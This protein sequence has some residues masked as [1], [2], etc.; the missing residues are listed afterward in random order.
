MVVTVT[1]QWGGAH[2]EGLL[3]SWPVAATV[4][5]RGSPLSD[6]NRGLIR[7]AMHRL[8]ELAGEGA[9]RPA[10]KTMHSKRPNSPPFGL[11]ACDFDGTLLGSDHQVSERDRRALECLR[12]KGVLVVVATGRSLFSF[13]RAVVQE[14]P[15]DW[16]VFS[17]GAGIAQW[18]V[19]EVV[20]AVH[21]TC[22]ETASIGAHLELLNAPYCVHDT[23]P[24]N[25]R[26]SYQLGRDSADLRRRI[27]LYAPFS[28]PL[29]ADRLEKEATQVIVHLEEHEAEAG[30]LAL[31]E[32]FEDLGVIRTTSPL[33]HCSTW[34]EIFPRGVSKSS[35]LRWLC[36]H[37]NV[38]PARTGA[39]GND[40][41]DLDMLEWVAHPFVVSN[42]AAPLRARFQVVRSHDSGGVAE[43]VE[44][45]LESL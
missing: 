32:H 6:E 1:Q 13:R 20:H 10:R 27:E 24:N 23:I 35:G 9:P 42:A 30:C 8:T 40:Y 31:R 36:E 43:A 41:N 7:Q 21:L 39:V 18:P 19:C 14:L 4:A 45:W 29:S 12:T 11:F 28:R 25:H 38:A 22:E 17:S 37:L 44:R 3:E 5:E 33:D 15:V 16:L 26:F 2:V 34:V